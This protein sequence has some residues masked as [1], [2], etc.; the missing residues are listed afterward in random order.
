MDG[1]KGRFTR[2]QFLTT[3]A[4]LGAGALLPGSLTAEEAAKTAKAAMPTKI[5]GKTGERVTALGFGS[6]LNVTPPLL[7]I[8]LAEGITYIDTAQGYGNGNSE[9]NIGAILDQNGRRKDCFIVTKS[10][11][12]SV[13]GFAS[14]LEN[15][16]LPRLRT[17]YVDLYYL[18]N[19]G[20][21]DRLDDE[22]K[23]TA[24]SLKKRKKIR[25]FGFSSHHDN[26]VP[27][28]NKAAEVGFVD[29]IMFKYNFRDY[30]NAEL[31]KAM[32]KCAKAGI[33][34]IAM[35]TQGGAV[36]FQDRVDPFTEKGFNK[37][38][39][40]L[41]AVWADDRIHCI[42]SAMKNLSQLKENAEAARRPSMG[43]LERQLLD[44]YAAETSHL[45]CRGCAHNCEGCVNAPLQIADT[46]RYR[47][48][49]ENY[50]DREE[51]RRL[52]SELPTRA[53]A[54]AG[55]DFTA[56]EAAC[57]HN[58]PIGALMRDAAAKLA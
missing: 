26:M 9:K 29:A 47:M 22:M 2:R 39:A 44:E 32:D 45:Y 38:Q 18:H 55:V 14:S 8:A 54:I 51:A 36:S 58:L 12:H 11:D 1:K 43:L 52:F 33:G 21:P 7:N 15:D 35:K 23:Q 28:L 13:E 57:P 27:T 53:R 24:E 20:D 31:N 37:H 4:A 34:L 5:L 16:S 46:L 48:Y 41:K 17:D 49:H 30:D 19:L 50:G 56:A 6:A 10:G 40:C 3:S 42:V 25:F